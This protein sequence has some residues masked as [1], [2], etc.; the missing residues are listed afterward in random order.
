MCAVEEC[1]NSGSQYFQTWTLLQAH[2]RSAHP[3]ACSHP[4]CGKKFSSQKNLKAHLKVHEDEATQENLEI[5]MQDVD[6]V[7][8][9]ERPSVKTSEVGRDWKCEW[10]GCM[11]N[12]KSVN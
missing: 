9:D 8:Q 3:P 6:S 7:D 11:K 5:A 4:N 1:I 2:I 12:F 10:E